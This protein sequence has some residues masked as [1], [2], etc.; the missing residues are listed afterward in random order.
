MEGAWIIAASFVFEFRPPTR[1]SL[2][3]IAINDK[4]VNDTTLLS[5]IQAAKDANQITIT[6]LRS[7]PTDAASPGKD[8]ATPAAEDPAVRFTVFPLV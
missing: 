3:A 1:E 6:F 7:P 8:A 4:E 5:S 2:Q